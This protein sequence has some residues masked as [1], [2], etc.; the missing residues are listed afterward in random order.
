MSQSLAYAMDTPPTHYFT[1][2]DA[3]DR[4]FDDYV[5]CELATR[6]RLRKYTCNTDTSVCRGCGGQRYRYG[7]SAGGDA[8]VRICEDCGVVDPSVVIAENMYGRLI[9]TRSSN[10]KRIHHWHERISQ[11]LLLE[12]AIPSHHLLAIGEKLLEPPCKVINKDTIRAALR[13]LGL[14]VYIEKWLQ[15]V[16]RI[17]G[18][19]PPAPGAVLLNRLD[20][21]FLELQRPFAD[22]KNP[23]RR[24]FLNYNYVFNRLLQKLGCTKFCMF[25]PLIRSKPKLRALDEMWTAMVNSIGWESP[26]LEIVEPF[27]VQVENPDA[28][29]LRLRNLVARSDSAVTP[30]GP[31][32]RQIP[33]LGPRPPTDY[34][35][36]VS[37]RRLVQPVQ[38]PQTLALR[39]KRKRQTE[40]Q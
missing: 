23:T 24:N 4:A 14:Q 19:A 26:P 11:L 29:L 16:E 12:S 7:T 39:L 32:K 8:G 30:T 5:Q 37:R 15:I 3:V 40:A 22:K 17:T 31:R 38:R 33:A 35:Q 28:L 1:D 6:T 2:Q 20:E 10:Y 9:P 13:S 34:Q 21:L 36:V 25:F 18:I 27:A